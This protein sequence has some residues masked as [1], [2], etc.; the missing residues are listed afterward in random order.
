MCV[1]VGGGTEGVMTESILLTISCFHCLSYIQLY[2]EIGYGEIYIIFMEIR[3]NYAFLINENLDAL[4]LANTSRASVGNCKE[5]RLKIMG[6]IFIT[7]I[8]F[9]PF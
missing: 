7:E 2:V 8:K 9:E 6:K 5:N 3:H 4:H 1:C